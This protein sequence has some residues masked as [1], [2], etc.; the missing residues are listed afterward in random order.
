[1]RLNQ[2]AY[3]M[4]ISGQDRRWNAACLR[5]LLSAAAV[6]YG[7]AVRLRNLLY[8][9]G[10]IKSQQPAI[11]VIS[12]G[13]LTTG[14]TGKTPLVIWL[15]RYL[16]SRSMRCAVLTRGYK[17]DGSQETMTDEPALLAK[18]CPT[19]EVIVNPNRVAGA[20]KAIQEFSAEVLV[21]D[22]GFQHRRMGRDL[23][24]LAIDATCPFGYGKLLPAGMLRE[25]ISSLSRADAVVITRFDQANTE[26]IELLKKQ[27]R[28]YRPDMPVACAA[29]RLTHVVSLT[30]GAIPLEHIRD[31]KLYA[32][33]GIGNPQAFVHCLKQDG[34]K[35]VGNRFFNDHHT[36]S[37]ADIEQIAA[38]MSACGAELAV[39]TQKDWVK[40]A[41]LCKQS[42]PARFGA[43]LMELDFAADGGIITALLDK[44]TTPLMEKKTI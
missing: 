6:P 29:H 16:T 24:I 2:N 11:P 10:I 18:S 26:Q 1:M 21:L 5:G 4:L 31:K 12:V 28:R 40:A 13:N 35:V 39:C 15:C 8:D 9:S 41:L 27:I 38:E 19:V 17:T 25:P 33:C 23:N 43:V 30:Q 34:L 14:G 20:R 36:F 3:R 32:F 7:L 42:N 22:D 44:L 37:Q